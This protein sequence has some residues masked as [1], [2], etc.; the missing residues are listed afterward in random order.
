MFCANPFNRL[1]IKADGSVYCCC[2]GWLPKSLGNILDGDLMAMWRGAAAKEIRETIL[3]GSFRHCTACPY[4]P[5]GGGPV[6][7]DIPADLSTDIIDTLKLDYDQSCNLTCPSCRVVHSKEF[8]DLSTVE[9]IHRAMLASGVL[10]KTRQLYVTGS[11]DPFASTVFWKFLQELPS[12]KTRPGMSLFLHTNG[13]L[14]DELHW[15]RM[16]RAREI[17]RTVGIS[18]D[19]ATDATYKINRGGSWNKLW[20]NIDFINGLQERERKISLGMFFTVQ[21]N[22]F[23]ELIPFV[24]MCFNH[25]ASWISVTA[26]RNWGTYS[27]DDY[28]TRA[29]HLP[30]HPLHTEFKEIIASPVLRDD[31]RIV[32]DSFNPE[33]VRQQLTINARAL[34]P[35]NRLTR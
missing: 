35:A 30:S 12:I 21:A 15:D 20:D 1:E 2:E 29:V 11:G 9:K 19:A 31:R 3:D 4:L 17:V 6:V 10:E 23:R 33:F 34:V 26:L 24:R 16:G 25:K 22:N 27:D 28:L 8:V 18:V 7:S 13:L 5:A 14:F 32:M